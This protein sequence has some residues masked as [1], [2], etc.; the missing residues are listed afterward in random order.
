MNKLELSERE[1]LL[2]YI[3]TII[4]IIFI[5]ISF[6]RDSLINEVNSSDYSKDKISIEAYREINTFCEDLK[7]EIQ[8]L[9][10]V[11]DINSK[12]HSEFGK[13]IDTKDIINK[14]DLKLKNILISQVNKGNLEGLD[15]YY[16]KSDT[17]IES[18][19][20]KVIEYIEEL[21]A[22]ECLY[23]ENMRLNRI[24]KNEISLDIGLR[25]Y[26]L[27]E[28]PYSGI[29]V[30]GNYTSE[31]ENINEKDENLLDT[32]FGEE[33]NIAEESENEKKSNLSKNTK[34]NSKLKTNK[35][36][37]KDVALDLEMQENLQEG[38]ENLEIEYN[39]ENE[40][41]SQSL[42]LE[43]FILIDE[44]KPVTI[45]SSFLRNYVLDWDI[46]FILNYDYFRNNRENLI[47]QTGVIDNFS[48][49]ENNGEVTLGVS[50]TLEFGNSPLIISDPFD[51]FVFEFDAPIGGR[52]FIDFVDSLG[53]EFSI[54]AVK[55]FEEWQNIEFGINTGINSYPIK[56]VSIRCEDSTGNNNG[57]IKNLSIFT[58]K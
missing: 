20:E 10:E 36:A 35:K 13:K 15:F 57:K 21:V 26:T 38:D 47:K 16:I 9:K 14:N 32:L 6:I 50:N 12:H 11:E 8:S 23:I 41:I 55:Q 22:A 42:N 56:I 52:I 24:G 25:E 49:N 4:L 17:K 7:I 54:E 46:E 39:S 29:V 45:G 48:I 33:K 18:N 31:N 2:I 40:E 51:L 3:L 43:K 37:E 30:K 58:K 5:Y 34:N 28:L 19:I 1:K 53:S 27:T 44:K